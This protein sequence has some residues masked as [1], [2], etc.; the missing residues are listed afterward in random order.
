[1]KLVYL[2][3]LLVL[4]VV[5]PF[6]S[7][8]QS[9]Q[10]VE[11]NTTISGLVGKDLRVS[12]KIKNNSDREVLLQVEQNPF[13]IKEDQTAYFRLDNKITRGKR[14]VSSNAKRLQPGEILNSFTAF[15]SSD[16]QT[17]KTQVRYKFFDANQVQ[18]SLGLTLNFM[19]SPHTSG[20]QLYAS[21]Y[22]VISNLYPNPATDFIVFDYKL[23]SNAPQAKVTIRNVLG[24]EVKSMELSKWDTNTRFSIADLKPG[25]YFYTLSMEDQNLVTRRFMVKK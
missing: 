19:V 1:M 4:F 16:F 22:I 5:L 24:S 17:G 6:F 11:G 9:L 10:I 12:I 14:A 3:Q 23:S 8:A 18:D 7:G 25:V 15:L 20:D 2:L 21:D 13:S